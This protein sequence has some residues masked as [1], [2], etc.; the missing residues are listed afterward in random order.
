MCSRAVLPRGDLSEWE[1]SSDVSPGKFSGLERPLNE[2]WN[3]D[4][5]SLPGHISLSAVMSAYCPWALRLC[6]LLRLDWTWFGSGATSVCDP[7]CVKDER[8]YDS[9]DDSEGEHQAARRG[10]R[11]GTL[12]ALILPSV[13]ITA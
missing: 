3:T 10:S 12:D 6:R 5:K 8:S 1:V 2:D 9:P 7:G 13:A 11:S 4:A